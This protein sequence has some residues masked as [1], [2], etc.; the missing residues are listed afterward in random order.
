MQCLAGSMT[1]LSVFV[2]RLFSCLRRFFELNTIA[3][4]PTV[5]GF[6]EECN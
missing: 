1:A 3:A 6:Y 4:R 5:K 2:M